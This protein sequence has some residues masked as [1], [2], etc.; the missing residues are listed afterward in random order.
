MREDVAAAGLGLGEGRARD[1]PPDRAA[2]SAGPR[3]RASGSSGDGAV[4]ENRDPPADSGD[5]GRLGGDEGGLQWRGH[6]ALHRIAV[7]A[8]P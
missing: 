7:E 1:Q 5:F 4:G 2:A 8:K 3:R 6:D